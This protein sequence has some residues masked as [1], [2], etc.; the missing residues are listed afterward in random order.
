MNNWYKRATLG[1]DL[2]FV[3]T[4]W[5]RNAKNS[6]E[7]ANANDDI[8]NQMGGADNEQDL[9]AAI[10]VATSIVSNEQGGQ[11]TP[12]QQ[13]FIQNLQSRTNAI[14]QSDP[15]AVPQMQPMNQSSPI[16]N[17]EMP[18]LDSPQNI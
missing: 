7:I 5:L 17:L 13:E 2:T 9:S 1:N 12:S 14:K 11:L 8:T 4:T 16:N 18:D 15:L 10:T 6:P 3:I